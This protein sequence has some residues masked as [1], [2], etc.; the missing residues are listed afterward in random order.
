MP[1][2]TPTPL[3]LVLVDDH[4]TAEDVVMDS[5]TS[6]YRRW[7][8]RGEPDEAYRYQAGVH[9]RERWCAYQTHGHGASS[10]DPVPPIGVKSA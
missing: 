9:W 1:A 6:L 4:E 2:T 7:S 3:R 5:F 10:G 8:A